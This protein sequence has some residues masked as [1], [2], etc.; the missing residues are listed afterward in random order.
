[1]SMDDTALLQ[2]YARTGA[3]SAFAT[4]VQRH[5]GVVYSAARR[6][7]R[8]PQ[9]AEDVTQAVFIVLARKAGQVARHPGLAGWLLL[10]TRY[11]ANAHIRTSIRRA[12][13]E[14]EAVMQSQPDDS[15]T[16][17]TQLEPLLDEAMASLGVT[18]RAV[19][20]MRYFENKTA[21]EIGAALKLD[22]E[23]ARK[24]ANRALEKLRKIF[25][26][27]GVALTAAAIAGAVSANSVQAAPVGLAKTISVIAASKGAAATASTLILV[28]QTMKTMLWN[29]LKTTMIVGTVIILAAGT[30]TLFAQPDEKPVAKIPYKMLEDG[31]LF[32]QSINPTNLV[33]HVLVGSSL[34]GV[35]PQD[36][37]LSIQST[38][39][40]NIPIQLGEKGKLLDF[41][42]DD[43]L[44]RENPFVV[45]DQ[46]KGTLK[47]GYW[48]YV[49]RPEGISFRYAVLVN[50]VD[51]AN[52]AAV[53]ANEM[54]EK[55][56]GQSA[57]MFPGTVNAVALVFPKA[58][59]GKANVTIA[60]K[61]GAKNYVADSHGRITLKINP[62][63]Q[64][65]NPELI[66]SERPD[67]I[68]IGS[69]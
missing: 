46:P 9:I 47:L 16:A 12:Q 22:E 43:N 21:A 62:R 23:T 6:Q 39:K 68:G 61:E 17:W 4:L 28:K 60:T 32:E 3:E 30:A 20:A 2:E 7:V 15:S 63:F 1:M 53:R 14:K 13:R 58:G 59:A 42:C 37:H 41:P 8:D 66:C 69:F 54:A 57:S 45:S 18:D 56:F 33:F 10:T 65:E 34:K 49:P 35:R 67:W 26:K 44:R 48:V 11:A 51:E 29:N 50:A 5:V 27:R 25:S 40:G 52:K 36:I 64:A 38:N 19:L 55:D 24:R 31:R